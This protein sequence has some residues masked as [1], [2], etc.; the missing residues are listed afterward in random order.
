LDVCVDVAERGVSLGVG[1]HELLFLVERV[2][3]AEDFDLV[4]LVLVKVAVQKG[5]GLSLH[6]RLGQDEFVFDVDLDVEICVKR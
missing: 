6:V 5:Y 2:V 3:G 4:E 1:Y